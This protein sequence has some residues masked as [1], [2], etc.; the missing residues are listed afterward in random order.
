MQRYVNFIAS[1]TSTSSTLMVLSNATC[2]VYVAGTTTAATLYSDNGITPLANPFLSSSTGQV[3]FYAANGLYDLVVSKIGYLT[4]TIS[5]IELDDLLASSGSS[6]VGYIAAGTGAV[7]TTVQTKLRESVSVKDFGA[8]GDGVADDTAAIQAAITS[9]QSNG[10]V[11]FFPR[12][13]YRVT[14]GNISISGI[15]LVGCG[16][17]EFGNTYD[18]NSSVILLDSTTTTPFV[19]GLGWNISGLTFFY[20]NQDGTAATPIVYPPLFTGTYVA[21]GIMNNVTVVNA[22][23]V[24]KFTS[25]TAVG[26]F[27]LDQCRMYGIDKVFWFLQGAPEVI[28]VSNCMFSYGIYVPAATPNTYLRDYTSLNGEF[29]RIDVAA[30]SH[31]SVD[32]FNLNQSLVFGYRYGIRVLSGNLSVSTINNNWF[33]GVSTALS[34]ESPGFTAGTRWTGNYHYSYRVGFTNTSYPTMSFSASGGGGNLLV[35]NNDFLFSQGNHILWNAPSFSDIKITDNRFRNW[36]RD[37]ASAPT[38]YYAINATDSTLNGIIGLNK[39]KPLSGAV[40]HNRNGIGIGNAA[41]LAIVS[42]EFDDC[43][44]PIWIIAATRVRILANTSTGSTSSAALKNDA[45]AGVLQSSG[46]RWDKGVSGPSGAPS[47]SA[48]AGTQTFTGAKTQAT[49]TNAEPFDRDVNFASSTFT[50]PSTDD[51]E[52]NVQLN[53]TT[54]VTVGDVW[55]L[56]I[57]QAGGGSGV[58][59]RSVYITANSSVSSPLSCSA[60]FSL[61]AGDTVIAYVTRISGTG[62]YVTINNAGYNTFTGKRLPY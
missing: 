17:P 38:S 13:K 54:G 23:Q 58:F 18:D 14:T 32:G 24:F 3:A 37:A 19:L 11:V 56:S 31:T 42:N 43:Y 26:D 25:G 28:N 57:E 22:Y 29:M 21:G 45:T 15:T 51:Y 12:G 40:A 35:S 10:G 48:N 36:G 53:N 41:D 8:V 2:T 47:F 50:A 44:L 49:F 1:T 59:A 46:N 20:P 27:R 62:N 39:F 61:T 9:A 34:V 33:D 7:A 30:S 5:D 6:G 55:T 52:F 16:T 4:V 60:T